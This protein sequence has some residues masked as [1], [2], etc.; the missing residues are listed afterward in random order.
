MRYDQTKFC[1]HI[2]SIDLMVSES[3]TESLKKHQ[4]PWVTYGDHCQLQ[5][6]ANREESKKI[7]TE[8]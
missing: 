5:A 3:L 4:N 8:R 1:G 6:G 2:S 7:H